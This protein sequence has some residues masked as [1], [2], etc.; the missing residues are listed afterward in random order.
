M[1]THIEYDPHSFQL[2]LVNDITAIREFRALCGMKDMPLS[3]CILSAKHEAQGTEVA[4][5]S[6][7]TNPLSQFGGSNALGIGFRIFVKSKFNTSQQAAISAAAREYGDG[8]FTL[9]KG[10]PGTCRGE[11]KGIQSFNS[12]SNH[13]NEIVA[14]PPQ[15]QGKL[16]H[17]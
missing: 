11:L 6:N 13:T 3:K 8:G 16:L 14:F 2:F 15:A 4:T 5:I 17:S 10:P 9:V 1:L 12:C 7:A